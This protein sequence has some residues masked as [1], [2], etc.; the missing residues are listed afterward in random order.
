[1]SA[2]K[3]KETL[4]SSLTNDFGGG[5][6]FGVILFICLFMNLSYINIP[7]VIS[8]AYNFTCCNTI[9]TFK[10]KQLLKRIVHNFAII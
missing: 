4:I 2:F 9:Y 5:T 8:I 6:D 1:M 3:Q 10:R 7:G